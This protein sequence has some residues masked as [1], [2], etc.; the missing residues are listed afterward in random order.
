MCCVQL[1]PVF[2]LPK[3]Q[4][5][6]YGESVYCTSSN[7]LRKCNTEKSPVDRFTSVVAWSISTTRPSYFG[8]A[9]YNP[10]LGETHHVSK[11]NLNVLLEQVLVASQFVLTTSVT[12]CSNLDSLFIECVRYNTITLSSSCCLQVSVNPPVSALHATDEKENIEMIWWQQPIP[13]FRGIFHL[14][15]GSLVT[16]IHTDT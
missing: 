13:R 14:F 10:I 9:P 6:C 8:V 15:L 7:L 1:P 11:G 12:L 4:L 3:S 16:Q 5:Q 2:N